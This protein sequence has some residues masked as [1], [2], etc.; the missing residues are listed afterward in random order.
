[1]HVLFV[2][3]HFPSYQRHFVRAMHSVGARVTGIGEAAPQYLDGELKSW[4]HGYEQ[5]PSV[6][7]EQAMLDAVRRVQRREWVD[8]LEVTIEAHILP[9]AKVREATGIPGLSV[10]AALLCRDKPMMK[11]FLRR[12]EV[13]C[14]QSAGIASLDEGVAFARSVGY[15]L[16]LKPRAAAGASGTSRVDNDE[17]LVKGLREMGVDRGQSVAIEEFIEG[18]EGFYDTM[19][20][21]GVPVYEFVSHYYPNV[22]D[23]MRN[24]WIT[25]YIVSTNRLDASGYDELKALGRRVIQTMELGTTA[26]HMEW[27]YGPKGLKFSEIGARPPGVG[28]WDVYAAG[29]DLDIY[30]EWANAVVHGR[31]EAR[32]SRRFASGIIALRPDRDGR[33]TGYTGVEEV[34]RKFGQYIFKSH[35]PPPGTPTQPIEAG[36]MANAWLQMRYPDYDGMREIFEIIARTIK[37]HAG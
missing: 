30:R 35:L 23:A 17:Q 21:N 26:T 9:V 20:V 11:E 13:P 5:V 8:R 32:P 7:D 29:N 33:I 19:S 37:V 4:L 2:A 28:Q 24:R 22:L 6:V 31:V 25:P 12:H 16:I 34:L 3:P 1:M 27:F 14:A 36:Y 15:P 18:H 10:Q